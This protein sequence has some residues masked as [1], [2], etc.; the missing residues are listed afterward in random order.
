MGG[1]SLL[2]NYAIIAILTIGGLIFAAAAMLISRI[3]QPRKQYS[4]K[5]DTYE[6]GFETKGS[7]W[8][9]F[10]SSYFVYALVYLIF[11]VEV[12]FLYPWAVEFKMLGLFAIVE[13]IIFFTLLIAAFLFAWKEGAFKWY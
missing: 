3:F 13:M 8:M 11:E 2:S 10:R 6:C 1:V 12:I 4:K 9:S 5:T 7:S